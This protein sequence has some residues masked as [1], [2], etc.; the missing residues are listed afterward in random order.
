LGYLASAVNQSK[1]ILVCSA[2][3]GFGDALCEL[4]ALRALRR[5]N[6]DAEIGWVTSHPEVSPPWVRLVEKITLPIEWPA[7]R[8]RYRAEWPD[9]RDVTLW[10]VKGRPVQFD[11]WA[12]LGWCPL[13]ECYCKLAGVMTEPDDC[14]DVLDIGRVPPDDQSRRIEMS[15]LLRDPY[16]VI[17]G[18]PN[19]ACPRKWQTDDRAEVA[20][21]LRTRE[22][23]VI[24]VAGEELHAAIPNAVMMT[25][26][27]ARTSAR[28]IAGA[29]LYVGS[30]TGTTWLATLAT[31]TP[32]VALVRPE[33]GTAGSFNVR[34]GV[35]EIRNDA[36]IEAVLDCVGNACRQS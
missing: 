15:G 29:T 9:I 33:M 11:K 4:V 22:F 32:V 16:C 17:Q 19:H 6:P 8:E 1:R 30:D 21:F 14:R 31:R 36:S 2:N 5:T 35:R 12:S 7:Y 13:P 28:I 20:R 3:G 24:A 34:P 23:E 10:D 27:P 18:G 25:N 26:L